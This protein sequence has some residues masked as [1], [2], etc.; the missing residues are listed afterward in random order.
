MDGISHGAEMGQTSAPLHF[1][2]PALYTSR[3]NFTASNAPA[4]I[5]P[6]QTRFDSKSLSNGSGS[7]DSNIHSAS[8][9][10][11]DPWNENVDEDIVALRRRRQST[12]NHGDGASP[13]TPRRTMGRRRKSENVEPGSAR[14]VYLEK[15]RKAASK[16]RTKQ[17]MQQEELIETAREF[18]RKNKA[19]KAEVEFLKAD[20][21]DL[22]E[23]VGQHTACPD[24]RLQTYVQHEADRLVARDKHNMVAQLL[25]PANSASPE[26]V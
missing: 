26:K 6:L 3:S 9:S 18:E 10:P 14:A 21:R 15:N 8:S 5:S 1:A 13:P 16:C 17:K 11:F 23:L 19:L 22:M 7:T 24:K 20:M 2:P 12:T 4:T 25:S